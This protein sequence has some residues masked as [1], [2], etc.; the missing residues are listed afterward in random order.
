VSERHGSLAGRRI[1]GGSMIQPQGGGVGRGLWV[2]IGFG[3]IDVV[4]LIN[5]PRELTDEAS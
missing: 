4:L 2:V 1:L 3:S 5:L